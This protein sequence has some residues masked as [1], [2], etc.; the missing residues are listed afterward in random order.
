ME[1]ITF[2]LERYGV[3]AVFI[4]V[5]WTKGASPSGCFSG[6][7]PTERRF[8]TVPLPRQTDFH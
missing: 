8:V 1:H 5:F 2:I 6:L 4:N 7:A 3:L